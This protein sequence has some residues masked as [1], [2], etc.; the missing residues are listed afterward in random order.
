MRAP[1]KMPLSAFVTGRLVDAPLAKKPVA[2]ATPRLGIE[3]RVSDCE[4][5]FDLVGGAPRESF[6]DRRLR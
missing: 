1:R 6:C 3:A 2:F 5:I 4:H